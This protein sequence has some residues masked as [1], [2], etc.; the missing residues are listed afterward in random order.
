[1]AFAVG[2]RNIQ[3]K[4]IH[5]FGM[6]VVVWDNLLKRVLNK[7][8]SLAITFATTIKTQLNWMIREWS[9]KVQIKID[10]SYRRKLSLTPF[11]DIIIQLK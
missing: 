6:H 8:M 2:T 9:P 10:R 1:M 11:S 5:P 4:Q 7:C 3:K